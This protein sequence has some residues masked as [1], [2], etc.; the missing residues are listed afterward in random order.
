MGK[1]TATTLRMRSFLL[2]SALFVMS[3]N[4]C[5]GQQVAHNRKIMHEQMR[6]QPLL[7]GSFW[8]VAIEILAGSETTTTVWS[9]SR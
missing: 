9:S 5:L 3:Y 6:V 7:H 2:Y 1:R 4:Y 8:G